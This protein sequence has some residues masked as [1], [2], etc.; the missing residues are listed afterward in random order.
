MLYKIFTH[1]SHVNR[2]SE[3][4][5]KFF[6]RVELLKKARELTMAETL[7]LIEV[8]PA[9]MSMIKSGVRNPSVKTLRRLTN[10]ERES[11]LVTSEP[12]LKSQAPKH[13]TYKIPTDGELICVIQKMVLEL[14]SMAKTV[15][16]LQT[17]IEK[18]RLEIVRMQNPKKVE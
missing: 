6:E 8:S 11:G 18:L 4:F 7:K 1:H 2:K 13:L 15:Q 17:E 14:T 12:E 10:A 16:M 3:L 9:M 5:V